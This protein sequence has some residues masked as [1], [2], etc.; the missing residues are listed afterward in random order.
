MRIVKL[1]EDDDEMR[2]PQ[3]VQ[4]FFEK[5]LPS[6][7]PP[8]RF[9]ITKGRISKTGIKRGEKLVLSYHGEIVYLGV[10]AS[11]R[12][13]YAGKQLW[14][15]LEYSYYFLIDTDRI[16]R[17]KGTL[18]DFEREVFRLNL[19]SKHIIQSQGWPHLEDSQAISE[20]GD[21]FKQN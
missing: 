9:L 4:D 17:G 13:L 12:Q 19:H 2:T 14:L 5:A 1:S 16:Y 11:G 18:D 6:K 20:L 7:S 8:G 10:A 21:Q 3:M 15:P